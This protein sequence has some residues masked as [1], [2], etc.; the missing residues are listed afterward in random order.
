MVKAIAARIFYA[1]PLQIDT[2]WLRFLLSWRSFGALAKIR[3]LF[4]GGLPC[5]R[6]KE[7][8]YPY[9][10]F[11]LWQEPSVQ[12]YSRLYTLNF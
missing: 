10:R 12:N 3:T 7:S 1:N 2:R 5:Q 6:Q 8:I 11:Y 9:A 4:Y